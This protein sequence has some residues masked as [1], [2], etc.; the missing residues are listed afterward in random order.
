MA[1]VYTVSDADMAVRCQHAAGTLLEGKRV[2][3]APGIFR[4]SGWKPKDVLEHVLFHLRDW[5]PE[6]TWV[7]T[8]VRRP[9]GAFV[10]QGRMK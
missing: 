2:I 5:Y 6:E 7:A 4:A 9:D 10:L 3:L 1:Q 8:L